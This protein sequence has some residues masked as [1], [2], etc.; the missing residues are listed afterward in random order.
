MSTV[1]INK[2]QFTVEEKYLKGFAKILSQWRPLIA[3]K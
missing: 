1:H 2:P 3:M